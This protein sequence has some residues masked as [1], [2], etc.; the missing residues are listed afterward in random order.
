[1]LRIRF[2]SGLVLLLWSLVFSVSALPAENGCVSCHK[3]PAFYSQY[4]KLHEYYQQWV[5]S[6]HEQA[7]VS[8]EDCHGGR[9]SAT[10]IEE[11][12]AGVLPM[13]DKRSTLYYQKQPETCGQCHGDKQR[14]F[15][16]SKHY[17][18]LMDQ[19]AAPTCTTCHPAMSRRPELRNIVLHACRNCHGEG[20]SE[21]LPLIA[22][23]AERVFNQLNIAGGLLGWT[24]I[25]YESHGWPDDSQQRVRDLEDRYHWILNRV[26]QFDLQQTEDS[27]VAI[28]MEL[29]KTFDDARRTYEQRSAED[30]A[31]S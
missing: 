22:D 29:R 12:H 30:A 25:H 16:Q 15:L 14:Q 27:I 19:R 6:P 20:N 11:A 24:R 13:N 10:S 21:N 18:A 1:M 3:N 7:G 5:A 9:A 31:E 8:C 26:H 4:P 23:Q 2:V 17:A 28:L